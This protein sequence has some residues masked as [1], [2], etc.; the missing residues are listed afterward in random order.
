MVYAQQ[1]S[2]ASNCLLALC[3]GSESGADGSGGERAPR[4]HPG[5]ARRGKGQ[6]GRLTRFNNVYN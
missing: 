4:D 1:G 6:S 2:G 5:D 3:D